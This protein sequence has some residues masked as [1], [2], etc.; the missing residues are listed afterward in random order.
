MSVYTLPIGVSSLT[1]V[2]IRIRNSD[3]FYYHTSNGYEA[4]NASNIANYASA[5]FTENGAT[6]S[7]KV[8]DPDAND[9]EGEILFV[10]KSGGS[11]TQADILSRCYGSVSVGIPRG[12]VKKVN[13]IIIDG[14][15][16]SNDPWGPA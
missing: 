3:G 10:V 14:A 11:L 13:D 1:A 5:N 6:G 4:Y 16:T 12:N 2:A 9:L 15:G 7:Y 8:T